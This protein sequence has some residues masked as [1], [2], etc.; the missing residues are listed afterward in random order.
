M[1][2]TH[3]VRGLDYA[4][5]RKI[6]NKEKE[7]NE[8]EVEDNKKTSDENSSSSH[9]SSDIFSAKSVTAGKKAE[10]FK[11]FRTCSVMAENLKNM[12]FNPDSTLFIQKKVSMSSFSFQANL[13]LISSCFSLYFCSNFSAF[14][15]SPFYLERDVN[16]FIIHTIH[17]SILIL[18]GNT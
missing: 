18:T 15:S 10:V 6:R 14:L 12:L 8:T 16:I 4:L 5:L 7:Q 3:L 9:R 11:D 17:T 2:H 1:E 13:F